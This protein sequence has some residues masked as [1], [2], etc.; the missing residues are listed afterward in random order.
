[1]Q[2][3][4]KQN[5]HFNRQS[6]W[7]VRLLTFV[8]AILVACSALYWVLRWPD[9]VNQSA[10]TLELEP[11]SNINGLAFNR[12]LDQATPATASIAP[13]PA[14]SRYVLVGVLSVPGPHGQALI[15]INGLPAKAYQVGHSVDAGLVLQSVAGRT[16][17]LAESVNG[18]TRFELQMPALR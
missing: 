18:P 3:H 10:P 11:E 13:T 6:L 17:A 7:T 16:A 12:L 2:V 5:T 14:N 15:S 9:S 8:L 1:M 4:H